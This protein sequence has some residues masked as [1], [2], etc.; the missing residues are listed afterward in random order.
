MIWHHLALLWKKR[1]LIN[2]CFFP[3][4]WFIL[5][6]SFLKSACYTVNWNSILLLFIYLFC[7]YRLFFFFFCLF[8]T[9]VFYI[10]ITFKICSIY[11]ITALIISYTL[12]T[13]IFLKPDFKINI[14]LSERWIFKLWHECLVLQR[15]GDS[16]R[17][18]LR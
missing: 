8:A 10:W 14:P 11:I 7:G 15:L 6:A 9:S 13:S 17:F 4:I 5:E 2:G 18:F 16:A 3:C 12:V 1:I